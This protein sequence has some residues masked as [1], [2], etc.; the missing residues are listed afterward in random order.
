MWFLTSAVAGFLG[1]TVASYTA[2][3][4]LVKPGVESL[5]IYTDVFGS[6]GVVALFISLLMWLLAPV[7]SRYIKLST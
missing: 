6:I 7:L 5:F 4:E 2:L 1:A 3:P